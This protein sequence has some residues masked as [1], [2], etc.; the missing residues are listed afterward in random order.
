MNRGP[1]NRRG[2][3]ADRAS[4]GVDRNL[5]Q[6]ELGLELC[7]LLGSSRYLLVV[8]LPAIFGA[9]HHLDPDIAI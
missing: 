2:M 6:R 7:C 8:E 1:L 9:K 5:G 4:L 3:L